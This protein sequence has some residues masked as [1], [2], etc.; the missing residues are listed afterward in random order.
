MPFHPT[1]AELEAELYRRVEQL[2]HAVLP[3][4]TAGAGF[5]AGRLA[6][7]I[8]RPLAG[9]AARLPVRLA[10][11]GLKIGKTFAMSHPLITTL[12]VIYIVYTNPKQVQA[13]LDQ[14]FEFVE[15]TTPKVKRG[16][17]RAN[18]A[19]KEGMKRLKAGT[20]S[21]TG[22]RPGILPFGAF[23]IATRAA[24]MANPNTPSQPGSGKSITKK[25]ARILRKWW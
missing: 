6:P 22:A 21:Q 17:S 10:I 18:K 12:G 1:R 2:E 15:G 5:V 8:A 7:S 11:T 14:G 4:A 16:L 24:G 25:L 19:V 20:K 23:A 3:A 13:L 9:A